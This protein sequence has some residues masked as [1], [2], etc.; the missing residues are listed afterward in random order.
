MRLI[1]G[2]MMGVTHEDAAVIAAGKSPCRSR[3]FPSRARAACTPW[4]RPRWPSRSSRHEHAQ[5]DVDLRKA[6]GQVT[7]ERIGEVHQP[8]A[9]AA[10]VHDRAAHDEKRDRK[11]RERLRGRDEL[12]HQQ[13]RHGRRVNE[14]EIGQCRGKERVG[15]RMPVKYSTSAMMIG[16]IERNVLMRP[17]PRQVY[18]RS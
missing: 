17:P 4:R 16:R 7:G 18:C 2:G 8:R 3:A 5:Q 12:L 13:V 10:V 1:P 11:E 15:D 9:D 6:A 14:A